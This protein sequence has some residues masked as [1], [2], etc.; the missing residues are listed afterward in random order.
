MCCLHLFSEH[1][2]NQGLGLWC[3]MSLQQY[4]NSIVAVS[5]IGGGNRS[6]QR[7]PATCRKSHNVV[8]GTPHHEWDSNSQ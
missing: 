5:F 2:F 6:T 1:I 3:L 7:K 8:S 4:F